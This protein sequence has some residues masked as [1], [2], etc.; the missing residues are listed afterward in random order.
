MQN[1]NSLQFHCRYADGTPVFRKQQ[2]PRIS[3][4]DPTASG[5]H[6]VLRWDI[7]N[8]RIYQRREYDAAGHPV[9]DIDF[10]IPTLPRSGELRPNHPKA[11][12]QHRFRVNTVR[13]G[14]RSGFIRGA[15]ESL[16][17]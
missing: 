5:P 1:P 8:N 16:E 11:P 12:H 17:K 7:K 6:S 2:P 9:R 10:T 3:G 15:A 4:P 14:P 13:I